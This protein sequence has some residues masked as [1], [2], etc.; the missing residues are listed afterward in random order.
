MSILVVPKMY[1]MKYSFSLLLTLYCAFVFAQE[2]AVGKLKNNEK[3]DEKVTAFG[4]DL[5]SS[6]YEEESTFFADNF[7]LE[8]FAAK[9]IQE[10][11]DSK[12]I[13]KK[14]NKSFKAGFFDQF[15]K[16]PNNIKASIDNDASYDIVNY[17]YHLDEQKYHLL[18]RLYSENEGINYHDYQLT[19]IDDKFQIEDIYVYS[20]GEYLSKVLYSVYQLGVPDAYGSD[21]E[22]NRNK[23]KSFLFMMRYKSLISN[24]KYKPALNILN[25]LEGE[26]TESKLYYGLKVQIASGINEVFK[27]EA[28][29]EFLKKFPNDPSTNLMAIDYYI[30]L[31][32]YNTTMRILDEIKE[33]TE[34]DFLEYIRGNTAWQF[35][36]YETAEK[37]YT[38]IVKEFPNFEGVKVDLIYLYDH[39]EKHEDNIVL[40]DRFIENDVYSKQDLIDFV[41]NDSNELKHLKNAKIYKRWKA[42]K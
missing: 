31:K 17:Y 23:L 10:E 35:E 24:K 3:N 6:F 20:I 1:R 34:D 18:F 15:K 26:F 38:F 37:A 9:V 13:L 11:K 32:D 22:S 14:F 19:Y 12:K 41:D 2:S 4:T 42:R 36:D 29:D 21:T 5:L 7:Y 27:L 33:V 16:F 28:I 25:K 30:M 40:F 8:G 39:L